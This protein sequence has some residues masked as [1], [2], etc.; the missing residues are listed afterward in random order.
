MMPEI[1]D[2]RPDAMPNKTQ[3]TDTVLP[4]EIS[5]SDALAI[6]SRFEPAIHYTLG[7]RFFPIDTERYVRQCSLWVKPAEEPPQLLVPQGEMT[8]EQLEKPHLA[9]F[10]SVIYLKFIEPLDILELAKYSIN[11]AVDSLKGKRTK[12]IFHAGKGR[13]ARVGFGSR[14]VDALFSLTLIWRGRVP[15]DSAAAAALAYQKMQ[16]EDERYTYYG[17]VI[18]QNGWF[19]LQ[20][21]YLY[22]FNNWRSGFFGVNDHEADW[23]MIS[24]YCAG[25]DVKESA[26]NLDGGSLVER[27]KPCW[28]AYASH[29]FSGDDLRRRWDDPEVQKIGDHPL[30]YAGAGSHASYFSAGEYLAEIELP[31]LLPLVKIVDKFQEFWVSVLHQAGSRA[32]KSNFNVFRIPFVDYARGDGMSIGVGSQRPWEAQYLD[33]HNRWAN[34]YRGLWGLYAQDPIAGENAPAG[35]VYNR[36]GNVRRSWYDPLGWAGMDKV[37]PPNQWNAILKT[38]KEQLRSHIVE[39]DESIQEKSVLLHQ[40]GL[41]VAALE[42][43]PHLEQTYNEELTNIHNL[44]GEIKELKRQVTVNI[45]KLESLDQYQ[46]TLMDKDPGS[47]R[48]HIHHAPIPS[49]EQSLRFGFLAELISA[50]S[51]GLLMVAVVL[52]IVF[53]RTYMFFGLATMIGVMIF[54]EASF[55]RRLPQLIKS[56]TI[57]LAIISALILL[58]E[59]FW[60]V[61]VVGIL[62]AGLFIM[63]ENIKELLR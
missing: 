40:L 56:L 57:G 13:L 4:L 55:R 45:A 39:L 19:V 7:E 35:P 48:R 50:I 46:Q 59:F 41:E 58:Y 42:N 61:I 15:G 54:L 30:V 20:Y 38:R 62:A 53:A 29:D 47:M 8:L 18:Q 51:V 14:F 37:V 16:S 1:L 24:I 17:R 5:Q 3:S 34:H 25:Q 33:A 11:Q 26:D 9:E 63:W 36:D 12:A 49:Q 28:V 52:L 32:K 43:Q 31:F 23:E 27:L 44:S 6:L 2:S 21:W 22:P 60:Q 10:G